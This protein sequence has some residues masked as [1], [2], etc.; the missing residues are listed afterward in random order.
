MQKL[1]FITLMNYYPWGGSEELWQRTALLAKSK[2]LQVE[3]HLF[4]SSR[5]HSKVKE[6]VDAGVEV[7][8]RKN[9]LSVFDRIVRR[10]NL[11]SFNKFDR[12]NYWNNQLTDGNS[13]YVVSG[14]T[15]FD[16]L[17]FP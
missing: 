3:A 1:V 4:D 12:D 13:V 2:G 11:S 9:V 14:G 15:T 6:L 17:H 7:S 8:F 5:E 16:C 10:L